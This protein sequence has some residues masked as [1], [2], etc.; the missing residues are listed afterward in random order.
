MLSVVACFLAIVVNIVLTTFHDMQHILK[1]GCVPMTPTPEILA[2]T[3]LLPFVAEG[4]VA[5]STLFLNAAP[6]PGLSDFAALQCVQPFYPVMTQVRSMGL[7]V[8]PEPP[9]TI[10]P[11]I[12]LCLGRDREENLFRMAQGFAQV[13]EGGLMMCVAANAL[14]AA[15]YQKHFTALAAQPVHSYS[16]NHCRVFWTRKTSPIDQTLCAQWLTG[17][18]PRPQAETGLVTQP[19]LF[20][21][22]KPDAGSQ[23]L[24][25]HLPDTLAGICADVGAGY[26][27]LSHHVLNHCQ[28]VTHMDLF[29]ADHRALVCAEKNLSSLRDRA[30]FHWC[31]VT[32]GL[33]QILPQAQYDHVVMNPPFHVHDKMVPA[34]GQT[35]IRQAL[36][37]LKPGGT[38]WLVANRTLPYETT[39]QGEKV[40]MEKLSE[41]ADYKMLRI[42]K[43]SRKA[44]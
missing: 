9:A 22:Q 36:S 39:L 21:W 41:T 3:L 5:V 18:Q 42:K 4:D 19:G 2:K 16:K 38:L 27:L 30:A 26:G 7:T 20:S 40:K 32:Q 28:A 24:L 8:Q 15:R 1:N 25:A 6:T 44:A 10:Y 31:D 11:Q 13:A 33:P 12:L 34:L 37:T 35:F 43:D 14:G 17:G 29:E 23:L